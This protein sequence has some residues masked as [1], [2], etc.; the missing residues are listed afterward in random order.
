[1]PMFDMLVQSPVRLGETLVTRERAK[2]YLEEVIAE[3]REDDDANNIL[4]RFESSFDFNVEPDLER[5]TAPLLTILFADDEL[6]PPELGTMERVMARLKNGRMV[7][8]PAGPETEGHRTQV[9][10]DVW[11]EHLRAFVKALPQ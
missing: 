8:V 3:T 7:L 11:R 4:Y 2:S 5:I 6:N 10:A 9:K 1:M